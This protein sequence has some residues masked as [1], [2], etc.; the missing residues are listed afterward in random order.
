M[1]YYSKVV[2]ELSPEQYLPRLGNTSESQFRW[3][4]S[5][6]LALWL[7]IESSKQQCCGLYLEYSDTRGQQKLLID[8]S[9]VSKSGEWVF[10]NLVKVPIK[11]PVK[12]V[13][14]VAEYNVPKTTI[15]L[16]ELFIRVVEPPG[17]GQDLIKEA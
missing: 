12:E 5:L 13:K 17:G 11:G 7:G 4:I 10:S 16:M 6:N 15:K 8:S 1:D 3:S 14:L 9:E 2:A